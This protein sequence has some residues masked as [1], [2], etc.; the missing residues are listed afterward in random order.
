MYKTAA[1]AAALL[2]SAEAFNA[3]PLRSAPA[4]G[5]MLSVRMED[6][7][8]AAPEKADEATEEEAAPP[9]P[10]AVEYSESMPFLVKRKALSGY[11]GDVGCDPVG[12]S[13]LL[14]MVRAQ[15]ATRRALELIVRC[16][17]ARRV[18]PRPSARARAACLPP[19]WVGGC[20]HAGARADGR[21][22]SARSPRACRGV[23]RT[24]C[25][26]RR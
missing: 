22:E 18:Y 6:A 8:A 12:F 2:G 11:V 20:S 1:L 26:R 15:P 23:R 17:A 13:E 3:A 14:P 4:A 7:P 25:G 16:S 24:G 9:A 19:P 21:A 10:P 5:R